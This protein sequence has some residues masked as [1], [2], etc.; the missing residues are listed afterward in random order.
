MG[1]TIADSDCH[2]NG[3][4]PSI[5]VGEAKGIHCQKKPKKISAVSSE[6]PRRAAAPSGKGK[7]AALF[8]R[9]TLESHIPTPLTPG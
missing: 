6:D 1:V 7:T 3:H 2:R 9:Y 8:Q 4:K 5:S